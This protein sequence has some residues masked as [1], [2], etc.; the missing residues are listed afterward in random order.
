MQR[1]SI[2]N[3][4]KDATRI[5]KQQGQRCNRDKEDATRKEDAAMKG[6]AMRMRFK[7]L[8]SCTLSSLIW[9]TEWSVVLIQMVVWFSWFG[10]FGSFWTGQER[11]ASDG[12]K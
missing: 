11:L 8:H 7:V 12:T 9:L 10:Q 5:K 2:C 4:D 1:G 6:D 3:G